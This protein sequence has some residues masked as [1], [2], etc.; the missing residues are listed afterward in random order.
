[1]SS[2][3]QLVCLIFSFFYGMFISYFNDFHYNLI[4]NKIFLFKI[5]S[6]ILYV[7]FISLLYVYILYRINYGIIH[8][9]FVI[10][11]LLGFFISGVKKRK[12]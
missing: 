1:M 5:V 10:L 6:S 7:Y 12:Y 3:I 4:K 11:L 9:Y 8:I 2:W